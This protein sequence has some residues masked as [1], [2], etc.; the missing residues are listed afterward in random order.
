MRRA[1]LSLAALL[2]STAC[3]T[4]E[5]LAEDGGIELREVVR[6]DGGT[7]VPDSS[8]VD[9]AID[10]D[11]TDG[12][13]EPDGEA[14]DDAA[15]DARDDAGDAEARDDGDSPDDADAPEETSPAVCGDGSLAGSEECDDGNTTAADGCSPTCTVEYCGDGV[16]GTNLLVAD[17]LESGDLSALPW[18][19]GT[20]YGFAASTAHVHGGTYAL[21]S[22]NAARASTTAR[23]TL[24]AVS[25]GRACFWYA[26]ESESCCDDFRFLVDG[27]AAL[28]TA[29][30]HTTWTEF[31]ADVTPG[32]HDFAFEYQKDGSVDTGWDAFFV[33]DVRLSS[34][35]VEE[36]DDGDTTGGDGCSAVCRREICGN[37]VLDV[38]EACDD[39]N[40]AALD[41][42]S[43]TCALETCGDGA[44]GTI[45]GST[46]GFEGSSLPGA[47]WTAGTPYGWLPATAH[48]RT[49]SSALGPQNVG[50]GT[51]TAS[52]TL[53]Q[54]FG[55]RFCFWYAGESESGYDYFRFSL[56]GT[57]LV[58]T[59][60][61]STT[62]TEFCSDVAAGDHDL[63]W[64]YQKDGS[65]DTGWDAWY[66]DDL[67]L[68][69]PRV[70]SCDDGNT[71]AGDGC[72]PTCLREE[73][74]NGWLDP[75]EEC[76]DGDLDSDDACT[77]S[78]RNAFCG[79]HNVNWSPASDGFETGDLTQLPWSAGATTDGWAVVRAPAT[80]YGGQYGLVSQNNGRAGSTG[81]VE[82]PLTTVAAGRVCFWYRGE[83][84]S[85]YDY[86]NFAL[87]GTQLVHVAGSHTTWTEACF[88]VPTPGAHTFRWEYTKD[89]SAD[90]GAD[91]YSIDDVRF[92]PI[93]ETCD[94]GNS[95]TG[96]GCNSTCR[97]E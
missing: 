25:D 88:D 39:G 73:C 52:L 56:D 17:D 67:S 79:D 33:D 58:T 44:V 87:D 80:A 4:V 89:G 21:G 77:A 45:Y 6:D 13:A 26:G 31:C 47:G 60:G 29:G 93:A 55:G 28:E 18:V 49:G 32:F 74:G 12:E 64:S 24:R 16:T 41:G 66:V 96:D 48:A 91:A 40:T 10:G 65:G 2:A 36:C 76:D 70:E 27:T 85:G 14:A 84:E 9:T 15:D 62:W 68:P 69:I 53:R 20:P 71:T 46:F 75:G 8:D 81:W 43:A 83:S 1:I 3:A 37:G 57:N 30:T 42:C 51:S 82:L 19:A 72:G 54:S 34:G 23:V 78:C 38:A 61:S 5:D 22:Q 90:V 63:A 97:S 95:V 86:F 35:S 11:A 50:V 94:D 92:P 59:A 7:D